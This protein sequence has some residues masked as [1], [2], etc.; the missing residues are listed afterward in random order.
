MITRSRLFGD[1][2]GHVCET[3]EGRG[4]HYRG[5]AGTA[6]RETCPTCGGV[7]E[8]HI[9]PAPRKVSVMADPANAN[10]APKRPAS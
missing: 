8:R 2:P 4:Y 1:G 9:E 3:C 5:G 6:R 7:G 10:S